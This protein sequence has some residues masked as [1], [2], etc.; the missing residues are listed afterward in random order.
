[1]KTIFTFMLMLFCLISLAQDKIYV[2][3]ATAANTTAQITYIDH[4]DLN[5]N[6]N[7]PIVYVNSF[8]PN[9]GDGVY[10]NNVSGLWY[11]GG[12]WAIYNEDLT[13][14]VEG[15]SFNIYIASDPSDVITHVA[16][17][18]NTAGQI[19]IINNP[20]LNGLNP[21]PFMAFSH[22]YNP[23]SIYNSGNYGQY[24]DEDNR[25]LYDEGLTSVP[26]GA[27]FKILI[28]GGIGSERLQHISEASNIISN[29]TIIDS[30]F[31]NGNPNATFVMSH[32]WGVGGPLT[33]VYLNK[34]LSVWYD[35][36]NWAIYTEDKSNFPENVAFDIII[37]PQDT[38][39]GVNDQQLATTI[40]MFPN[41]AKD[42]VNFTA[43]ESIEN[44]TVFN[45]LGQ[46]V[47]SLNESAN[48]VQLDISSFATGA[49]LAKVKTNE[50]SQILRLI[51][52]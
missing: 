10:N 4:P 40:S 33:Q 20:M 21:G 24:Y 51:K 16:T 3:T 30:P 29:W 36:S 39:A 19:T 26:H 43:L 50:A 46:Q 49:Y 47:L 41:P 34:T 27:A 52:E 15:A 44:I 2:H 13:D 18:A 38:T 48:K 8:N 32:Y 28:N 9:I 11:N 17:S 1:M 31:L 42:I 12:N 14:M 6:P 5:G 35:G 7:A 45:M 23:N 37:A 25:R 22:Y